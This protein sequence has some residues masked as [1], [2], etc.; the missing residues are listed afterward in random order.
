MEEIL[1]R[2]GEEVKKVEEMRTHGSQSLTSVKQKGAQT[3]MITEDWQVTPQTPGR[4]EYKIEKPPQICNFSGSD[5]IPKDEGS[6][7]QWEFQV[8]G[9]MATHTE[10][11]VRAAIVN[12]LQGPARDL[13]GFVGFDADIE[14]SWKKLLGDSVVN[15]RG[16]NSS[17]NF[18]NSGRRR[19]KN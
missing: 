13:I 9:A 2:F 1:Q 6:Y 3:E 19:E 7:E 8:R 14:K 12:S 5:P 16:I 18:I 11:S 17:K 4:D 10:N 15:T